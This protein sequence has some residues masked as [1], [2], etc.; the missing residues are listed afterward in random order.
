[1]VERESKTYL[2]Q[3]YNKILEGKI[4]V[5]HE[6]MDLLDSL[7]EDLENPRYYYDT[8]DA[9]LRIDII[10]KFCKHTQD[11]FVGQPFLLELWEKAFI[12][13]MYSFKIKK[14]GRDRFK[15]IL[16]LIARRNGKS[17]LIAAIIFAELML[18]K[19]KQIICASN[20]DDQARIIFKQVEDMIRLFDPNYKNGKMRG[21]YCHIN[22][23]YI[24]NKIGNNILDR[25]TDRKKSGLGRN[26]N[27]VAIDESNQLL[28]SSEMP[29]QLYKG[30][31]NKLNAKMVNITTEGVVYDG[32]LDNELRQAREILRGERKG[33]A[34]EVTLAWLYTMDSEQEVWNVTED[35]VGDIDH[36]CVWQK[37]NPNLYIAVQPDFL[38][39]ELDK[40]RRDPKVRTETL[41]Y[42]FNIKQSALQMWLLERDYT[43]VQEKIKLEDFRNCIC[44]A[45]A[46]FSKTTD[47]TSVKIM[48]MKKGD[49]RKYIFSKYFLPSNKLNDSDDKEAG[50]KYL[51]WSRDRLCDIHE[52]NVVLPDKVVEWFVMLYKVYNIRVYKLGYDAAYI[53]DF[54]KGM[55]KL[56]YKD[57]KDGTCESISQSKYSLSSPMKEV[58]ADLQSELIHGLNDMDKW[59]LSNTSF[60]MDNEGRIKPAK[61]AES[62]RID[63]TATLIMLYAIMA[64]YR[65]EYLNA[66]NK[67]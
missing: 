41:I 8:Y 47:L 55:E 22:I 62:K 30:F 6:L 14:N 11:P 2:E 60:E 10:E 65:T 63:G 46:D 56:G 36:P 49:N 18:G 53:Y 32:W 58:K 52:G 45:S 13:V 59:C 16:L 1:M 54:L 23:S 5:G 61:A 37:A 38:L 15:N 20:N 51:E 27:F 64:R 21:K 48:F 44:F 43:Y 67:K 34:A 39:E 7:I 12:E 35:T 26:L 31:G 57:G 42:N 24:K 17:T 50:A 19:G 28:A 9:Y 25:M 29:S 3:Y 33:K 40:S 4:L 66:I